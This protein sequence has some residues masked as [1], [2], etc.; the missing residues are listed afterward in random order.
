M[1]RILII[2]PAWVGDVVMAQSLVARL[3]QHHPDATIDVVVPA[4]LAP[5]AA[6]MPG[7]TNALPVNFTHGRVGILGS[8]RFGHGLR[9]SQYDWAIV[10]RSNWKSALIPVAAA[11]P[12]R[13]G[14]L[15]ESRYFVLN[16]AR[17]NVRGRA[18]RRDTD[19]RRAGAGPQRRSRQCA[20]GRRAARPCR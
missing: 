8:L 5:L 10:L 3:R 12:R 16:E 9:E 15:G 2:A 19:H 4:P 20:G 13:R 6:R 1:T 17:P 7:V 18:H 11:I 14:Y